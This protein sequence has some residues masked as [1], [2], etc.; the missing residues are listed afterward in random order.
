MVQTEQVQA[1]K[2]QGSFGGQNKLMQFAHEMIAK[3]QGADMVISML[4]A[5]TIAAQQFDALCAYIA[6]LSGTQTITSLSVLVS[7]LPSR[8]KLD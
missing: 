4:D 6:D 7:E 2:S 1:I 3:L 5:E 8:D